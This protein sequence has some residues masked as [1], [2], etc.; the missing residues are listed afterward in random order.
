MEPVNRILLSKAGND[1]GRIGPENKRHMTEEFAG[2]EQQ[3]I[4]STPL[5]AT[6]DVRPI[7][8]PYFTE[9]CYT[10]MMSGINLTTLSAEITARVAAIAVRGERGPA[11]PLGEVMDKYKDKCKPSRRYRKVIF[12][13]GSNATQFIDQSVMQKLMHSDDEW[14]IKPHP[15]ILDQML[16]ELCGQ[17]GPDRVI[18]P[19][20][21][22]IDILRDCEQVATMQTSEMY[23]L[24]RMFDKPVIDVTRY[25]RAWQCTYHHICRLLD[26]TPKDHERL[27]KLLMGPLSGH[28]RLGY[29]RERNAELIRNYSNCAM[30]LREPFK[31]TVNQKMV[32]ADRT[33]KDWA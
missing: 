10:D 3:L 11:F 6:F 31:L 12:L 1:K 16:R 23:I 9:F 14:M 8:P 33:L 17:W 25:D 4:T 30:Q 24:A 32:V 22:G 20:E 28:I 19:H 27:N 21:S 5:G 2:L 18:N 29:S 13:A 7:H 26:G 15:V